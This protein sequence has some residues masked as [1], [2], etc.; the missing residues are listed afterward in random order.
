MFSRPETVRE[1]YPSLDWIRELTAIPQIKAAAG[2]AR[3]Y[4]D[5]ESGARDA[6]N[7]FDVEKVE[8]ILEIVAP[9]IEA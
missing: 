4:L 8:R 2:D 9:H 7:R 5:L 3:V 1:R 6:E